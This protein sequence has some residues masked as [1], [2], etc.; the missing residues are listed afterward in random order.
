[1]ITE[2]TY[3][4]FWDQWPTLVTAT[5]A[6]LLMSW[7][8]FSACPLCEAMR[9]RSENARTSAASCWLM[10]QDRWSCCLQTRWYRCWGRRW[11]DGL[12]W[13]LTHGELSCRPRLKASA[14][15]SNFALVSSVAT[16]SASCWK[17]SSSSSQLL[18]RE[19]E[20]HC[21]K[22]GEIRAAW[23]DSNIT[24]LQVANVQ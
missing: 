17:S 8:T 22:P 19:Q 24:P 16:T 1:M 15:D 4:N 20:T 18:G 7:T 9:R 14:A 2:S 12:Q 3:Q 23:P 11:G 10:K 13:P 21:I 6:P 5:F